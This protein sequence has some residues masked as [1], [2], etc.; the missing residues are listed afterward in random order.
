MFKDLKKSVCADI[1][2]NLT[3]VQVT[4]M[5]PQL[6]VAQEADAAGQTRIVLV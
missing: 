3:C 2:W 5:Y 4:A 1:A 6:R